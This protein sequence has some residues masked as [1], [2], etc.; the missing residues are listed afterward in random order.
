M[1]LEFYVTPNFIRNGYS[2]SKIMFCVENLGY[3]GVF[4][5]GRNNNIEKQA[6]EINKMKHSN[7]IGD[8]RNASYYTKFSILKKQWNYFSEESKER[9][10]KASKKAHEALK[11]FIKKY[12]NQINSY[13]GD[14]TPREMINILDEYVCHFMGVIDCLKNG[15][16]FEIVP[17]FE[18]GIFSAQE[19]INSLK[20]DWEG[21]QKTNDYCINSNESINT[22]KS[23]NMFKIIN[24]GNFANLFEGN[25]YPIINIKN[26]YVTIKDDNG[27]D[28]IVRAD[29]GKEIQVFTDCPV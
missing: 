29:R 18:N 7:L 17:K 8:D 15:Y 10:V 2:H 5:N 19:S 9:I 23:I 28:C 26:G 13:A 3:F 24:A 1:K 22:R 11:Y 20:N 25:F 16:D 12:N 21:N 4:I 14:V 6:Y 27:N